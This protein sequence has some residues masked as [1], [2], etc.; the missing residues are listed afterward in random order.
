MAIP[1]HIDHRWSAQ[2]RALLRFGRRLDGTRWT[3]YGKLGVVKVDS[4]GGEIRAGNRAFTPGFDGWRAEFGIGAAYRVGEDGQLY[5][6]YEYGRATAY[7]RPW[8]LNLGY[9]YLW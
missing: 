6:D 8:S 5:I 9:R 4:Q 2:Y 1:V 3:P 7:E